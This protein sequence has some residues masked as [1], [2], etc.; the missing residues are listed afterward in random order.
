MGSTLRSWANEKANSAHGDAGD[1]KQGGWPVAFL[2]A[3]DP[4][5]VRPARVLVA[6]TSGS[7]KT[8][9]AARIGEALGLPHIEID[10]LYHGPD[11]T[12]RAS[13][14]E[15]VVRLAATPCWVTE[16][17]HG[18]VRALLADRAD[19]LVW[20]DLTKSRVMWQVTRR[21]LR[22]RLRREELWHG[23]VEPPLR[24]IV[25]NR[26]HVVRWAWATHHKSAARIATVQAERPDLPIV[27]LTTR[28]AI[29][30]WLAGPV[31]C[32]ARFEP[33]ASCGGPG[34]E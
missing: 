25:T 3:S 13:F 19:L 16:W 33:V 34:A 32:E 17:Q 22:R 24:T 7:G 1:R 31:R 23:N 5:L 12:P 14:R 30:S 4:L 11:W 27:R 29:N 2:A 18:E 6:G 28:D 9:V 21:T 8:T 26:E 20:L 15:D 10:G